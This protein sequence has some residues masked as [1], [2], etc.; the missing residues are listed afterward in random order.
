MQSTFLNEKEGKA[1]LSKFGVDVPKSF[2]A[3]SAECVSQK[4]GSLTAPFVVKVVSEDILHK[5][6]AGG[7]TI[8]LNTAPEVV[9]AITRMQ[10][11]PAI[12]AARVDGWL[13]EEM[14]PAGMEVAI[15]GFYDRQF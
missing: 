12:A 10:A 9:E 7:V 15:G 6:D 4:I 14:I 8:N 1:L 5:S 13:V 3:A 11:I 2:I